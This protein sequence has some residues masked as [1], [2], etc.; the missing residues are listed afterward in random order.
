MEYTPAD[1]RAIE[2]ESA[3]A[4]NLLMVHMH[5]FHECRKQLENVEELLEGEATHNAS[6]AND[7]LRLIERARESL[8]KA[9]VIVVGI[10]MRRIN[11]QQ[12]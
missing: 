5:A 9:L 12:M 4:L 3:S 8:D 10:R 11:G 2:Q 6:P 7:A 1:C